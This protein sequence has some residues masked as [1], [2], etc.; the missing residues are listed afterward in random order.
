MGNH[1]KIIF[2]QV[3]FLHSHEPTQLDN[4]LLEAIRSTSLSLS[5]LHHISRWVRHIESFDKTK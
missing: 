5:G 1:F 2:L 4:Q 3:T